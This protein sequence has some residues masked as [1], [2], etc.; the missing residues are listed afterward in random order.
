MTLPICPGCHE[1]IPTGASRLTIGY[2]GE[3]S[4][5]HDDDCWLAA[6]VIMHLTEVVRGFALSHSGERLRADDRG[7]INVP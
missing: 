7:A 5:Y 4:T 2:E 1:P 3:R 6:E